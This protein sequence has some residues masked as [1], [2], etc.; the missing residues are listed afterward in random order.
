VSNQHILPSIAKGTVS[1]IYVGTIAREYMW[2]WRLIDYLH[3]I[4][5][6]VQLC[7]SSTSTEFQALLHTVSLFCSASIEPSLLFDFF[8]R[9]WALHSN[10]QPPFATPERSW[11][12][13]GGLIK[14]ATWCMVF[15]QLLRSFTFCWI[16]HSS[17]QED[18]SVTH[19]HHCSRS[20]LVTWF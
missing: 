14:C 11:R 5:I 6:M 3:W 2:Y 17:I 18:S 9:A 8:L 19:P 12:C 15:G 10:P 1:L 4:F 20:P 7:L 13:M 16:L